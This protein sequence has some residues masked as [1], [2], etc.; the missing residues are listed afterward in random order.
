MNKLFWVLFIFIFCFPINAHDRF[1]RLTKKYHVKYTN[2]TRS[3]TI[4]VGLNLVDLKKYRNILPDTLIYNQ[5]MS[6]SEEEPFGDHH[7]RSTNA[8]ETVHSIN[9]KLRNGY[10][11]ALQKNVNGFYAGEGKGIIV[12]NP[13]ITMRDIIPYIPTVVRGYR[14]KLYFQ[15]QLGAW[16]DVP[17]YPMDEWSSYIAG[18]ETAVDD[19]TNKIN[20]EKAD[21][22]SGSLEF[23]IYCTALAMAVKDR[24]PEFWENNEQ[25]KYAVKYYLIKS[26]RIFFEGHVIFPSEKQDNLLLM[27]REHKDTENMRN[28][29]IKE[30]EGIFVD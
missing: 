13:P 5:I 15:D 27:L 28:F 16:N 26:E 10:K 7:G 25:F 11:I 9:N 24:C 19:H 6:Y 8:H 4:S 23:S 1:H 12:D 30:F 3:R 21:S 17:T 14:F 18:A 20:T 29:L 2:D 22:V